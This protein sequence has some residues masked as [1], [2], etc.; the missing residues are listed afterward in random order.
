[1][2]LSIHISASFVTNDNIIYAGDFD[3]RLLK[4]MDGGTTWNEI[5]KTDRG[6]DGYRV[7]FVDSKGNIFA[8]RD[9][10]GFLFRS[11]D[12]GKTFHTNLELSDNDLSSCWAIAENKKGWLFASEYAQGDMSE[13]CAYLYRSK[14]FGETWEVIYHNPNA[15]HFHT[16]AI[17][18]YTGY[19]YATSGDG[20]HEAALYRSTDEGDHWT[21][22]KRGSTQWQFTSIAFTRKY[23]FFGSDSTQGADIYRTSDDENFQLALKIPHTEKFTFWAWGRVDRNGNILFGSW[24]QLGYAEPKRADGV[25]YLSRDQG[26]TWKKV[27]DFG[28][29]DLHSGT[30]YASN[31]APDG[32]LYCHQRFSKHGFKMRVKP[33]NKS[34][35]E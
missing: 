1:M 10:V 7:V 26:E 23:R 16:L 31:V 34:L 6:A 20:E 21:I 33:K 28:T 5:F 13:R 22:L 32:W 4:S 9:R 2:N 12:Q 17:D 8:C 19:I 24:T 14:D 11:T 25:I 18:P 35:A 30:H 29:T 3:G 15:R 27:M